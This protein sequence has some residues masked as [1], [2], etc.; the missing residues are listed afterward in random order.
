MENRDK[1]KRVPT[2]VHTRELDRSIAKTNMKRSGLHRIGKGDFF[3]NNWRKYAGI[4]K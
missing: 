4:D 3:H 2:R 1:I